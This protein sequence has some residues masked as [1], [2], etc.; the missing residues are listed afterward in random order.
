ML[1]HTVNKSP[2]QSPA[3]HSCLRC[4]TPGSILLLLEDGVYSGRVGAQSMTAITNSGLACY[5]LRPDVEARGLTALIAPGVGLIDYAD[6]VR[7]SVE[8]H[9]VQ[10]W[11]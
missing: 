3:L 2:E 8:C 11:Y 10:S 9:A 5:A 4:A 6:F 7:L 1:L